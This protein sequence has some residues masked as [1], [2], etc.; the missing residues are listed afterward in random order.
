MIE[1]RIARR[2]EMPQLRKLAIDTSME[3]FAEFNTPENMA[4]FLNEA[5]SEAQIEKD[6]SEPG[7]ILYL[8]WDDKRL[9]GFAR[10]RRSREAADRLGE[11]T[12]ELH[13]LYV[14]ADYQ[15][16]KVGSRLIQ[17]VIDYATGE[18]AEWLWL[19]VW[20]HNVKAQAFYS[21]WGFTRFSEHIFPMGD[22]PQTDWLLKKRLT[23]S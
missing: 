15:G 21:K 2:E 11:N 16:K 6:W 13:R 9:V 17:T 10:V 18:R 22:D 4:A 3:T 5:Y 1:I 7:A 19:G 8:A 12:I 20:E 23:P 14:R